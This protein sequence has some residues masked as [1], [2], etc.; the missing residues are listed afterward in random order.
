MD[1][2]SITSSA[3]NDRGHSSDPSHAQLK[4][5]KADATL[6]KAPERVAKRSSQIP[7]FSLNGR[8]SKKPKIADSKGFDD[9][10]SEDELHGNP[11]QPL[12]SPP[13]A[14]KRTNFSNIQSS[15]ALSRSRNQ[16]PQRLPREVD[17]QQNDSHPERL[18]LKVQKAV[19]GKEIFQEDKSSSL[20]L[21]ET[22]AGSNI[23]EPLDHNGSLLNI[24]WL[25]IEI[26]SLI[27]VF[28]AASLSRI[29]MLYHSSTKEKVGRTALEF[30]SKEDAALF[31]M[32][33]RSGGET[34]VKEKSP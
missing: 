8:L 17:T 7:Q 4:P 1:T 5:V 18:H 10:S 11:G 24:R 32:R 13:G 16:S 26:D 31:V 9:V 25:D 14:R 15:Q 34:R 12:S 22:A 33:C 20:V 28:H 19:S 2:E 3:N 30:K 23:V 6:T 27:R 29:L 21:V